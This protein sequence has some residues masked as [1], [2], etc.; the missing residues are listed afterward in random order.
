MNIWDGMRIPG[1]D[2]ASWRM[3]VRERPMYEIEIEIVETQITK[4]LLACGDDVALTVFVVPQLGCDPQVVLPN[5]GIENRLQ[6]LADE[7]LVPIDRGAVEMPVSQIHREAN[8]IGDGRVWRVIG[9][10]GTES[11]SG[12]RS[13]SVKPPLRNEVRIHGIVDW[14]QGSTRYRHF[15]LPE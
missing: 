6:R 1:T 12:Y 9:T 5:P 2:I 10:K 14:M 15:Q 7:V 11:D 13:A 8:C 3:M 4:G